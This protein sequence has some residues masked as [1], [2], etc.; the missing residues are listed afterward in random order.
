MEITGGKSITMNSPMR[1]LPL[2]AGFVVLEKA[3]RFAEEI[4][5]KYDR[6]EESMQFGETLVFLRNIKDE[7]QRAEAV[8]NEYL[9]TVRLMIARQ[10]VL[11]GRTEVQNREY[12]TTVERLIERMS[13]DL[14][15]YDPTAWG[16]LRELQ[17]V[18]ENDVRFA[19]AVTAETVGTEAGSTR[20]LRVDA[21]SLIRVINEGIDREM[22][23]EIT[24]AEL[25]GPFSG[26]ELVF[27]TRDL[28]VA[29]AVDTD[30]AGHGEG[31]LASDNR[32]QHTAVGGEIKVS[33]VDYGYDRQNLVLREE[34]EHT[35][36]ISQAGVT[37][38]TKAA[39]GAGIAADHAENDISGSEPQTGKQGR[40]NSGKRGRGNSANTETVYADAP[41]EIAPVATAGE[42]GTTSDEGGTEDAIRAVEP[43]NVSSDDYRYETGSMVHR[44]SADDGG[45]TQSGIIPQQGTETTRGEASGREQ[46]NASAAEAASGAVVAGGAARSGVAGVANG[47]NV[48]SVAG[49]ASG[50]DIAGDAASTSRVG[51][52]ADASDINR[53]RTTREDRTDEDNAIVGDAITVSSKDYAYD[54]GT[55]VLR[56]ETGARGDDTANTHFPQQTDTGRRASDS[57][58]NTANPAAATAAR[59]GQSA[60]AGGEAA[61]ARSVSGTDSGSS[62]E[63][64]G[65]SSDGSNERIVS[66][67]NDS[68]NGVTVAAG[69]EAV[70]GDAIQV[71]A[72]D[73][74][75]GFETFVHK[76]NA[77]AGSEASSTAASELQSA[78]SRGGE[79][80]RVSRAGDGIIVSSGDDSVNISVS[81]DTLTVTHGSDSV[82]VPLE[83]SGEAARST[84]APG[85]DDAGDAA[86]GSAVD[87][88]SGNTD[89]RVSDLIYRNGSGTA[90]MP[91]NA[92]MMNSFLTEGA[93]YF[94]GLVGKRPMSALRAPA[95]MTTL[96]NSTMVTLPENA[97]D[98]AARGEAEYR[99]TA[100]QLSY[101]RAHSGEPGQQARPT[102]SR[103]SAPT[104]DMLVRQ[105]GNLIEGAD[106]T[107]LTE[108]SGSAAFAG[109]S[110][111]QRSDTV[112][113]ELV[114][115]VKSAA[116]KSAENSKMIE[117]IRK[118]QTEMESGTLK[119]SDMRVISD[120]VITR[121]RSEL[122]FDR[123]RYSG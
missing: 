111:I 74:R 55:M 72:G 68:S 109:D 114:T 71:S 47:E 81:G 73:Y 17:R 18:I 62:T 40:R 121:L 66:E 85:A 113:R 79:P 98:G 77:E 82:R 76:E 11:T 9:L 36:G 101:A 12:S 1:G 100:A 104:T 25:F 97:P 54:A 80:V 65:N 112:I 33:S 78:G 103:A 21:A 57:G 90:E 116:E 69:D 41:T 44:E 5:A 63:S 2:T 35:E 119:T 110:S 64:G 48:T 49:V 32:E 13:A 93:K 38:Q 60:P 4:I 115:A 15:S 95:G 10:L 91:D 7:L 83:G 75:Y 29:G 51:D 84:A 67:R 37:Q 19:E 86:R 53:E 94:A 106:P 122:R 107:G 102:G 46:T 31:K 24:A 23:R 87:A 117:E 99:D 20:L 58:K 6:P 96:G 3:V 88:A 123:S 14:R 8:R 108:Q 34:A 42:A 52:M 43:V 92:I 39:V 105:F 70:V 26:G 50:A 30:V 59:T 45:D 56:D 61:T 27:R 28:S 118:R 89:Y 22:S 120:E 16:R